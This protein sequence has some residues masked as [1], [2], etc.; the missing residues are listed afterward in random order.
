E[1]RPGGPRLLQEAEREGGGGGN[2]LVRVRQRL[3]QRIDRRGIA[4]P[5]RGERRLAPYQGLGV[6]ERLVEQ[7]GVEGPAVRRREHPREHALEGFGRLLRGHAT[8][9]ERRRGEERDD[10]TRGSDQGSA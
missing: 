9:G 8:A 1:Q 2:A 10:A 3:D 4:D 7:R 6:L 5:S